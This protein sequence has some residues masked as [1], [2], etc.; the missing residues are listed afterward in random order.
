M[1]S[2]RR[3]VPFSRRFP[4]FSA[5]TLADRLQSRGI[6]YIPMGDRLGGR[7]ANPALYRDGVAD[8]EAM[9][10]AEEFRARIEQSRYE[11]VQRKVNDELSTLDSLIRSHRWEQ[12]TAEAAR[13]TRLYPD[14]Q[15]VEG[16]RHQVEH[17]RRLYKSDLERRFLM[18]A[19]ENRIG[20]A[21]ELL[22][23]LDA[24]LTETEAEP[25]RELARGVIGKARDRSPGNKS[26][27]SSASRA[28]IQL[29]LPCTVL[30]SPLCAM[31]RY[32]WASGHDGNVLVEKR[33]WTSASADSIRSSCRSG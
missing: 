4:W 12:A 27:C 33:E 20:D 17:A 18:A 16:L 19:E 2:R 30:I 26:D 22:R 5:R 10:D 8:Y 3:S 23:E 9:A 6:A 15:R 24:Y 31:K 1:P 7:P 32:G 11:T 28:C 25:Y 29:R 13:I 21:M 14:S